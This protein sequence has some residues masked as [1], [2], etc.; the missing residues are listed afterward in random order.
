MDLHRRAVPWSWQHTSEV[1]PLAPL[2]GAASAIQQA[3]Q[4]N[5]DPAG[6]RLLT[7]SCRPV[8]GSAALRGVLPFTDRSEHPVA[9]MRAAGAQTMTVFGLHTPHSVFGEADP[10]KL[11]NELA[12]LV[13]ASLNSG[14]AGRSG[15]PPIRSGGDPGDLYVAFG[16]HP[17]RVHRHRHARVVKADPSSSAKACFRIGDWTVARPPRSP[18]IPRD[19][20]AAPENGSTLPTGPFGAVAASPRQRARRLLGHQLTDHHSAAMVPPSAI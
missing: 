5:A 4:R 8:T 11:R 20:T 7:G 12:E 18:T 15:S 10:D 19:N 6:C 14:G 9:G 3:R 16:R 2:V 17:R 13:L 1:E